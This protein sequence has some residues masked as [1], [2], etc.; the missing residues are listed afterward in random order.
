M[1]KITWF[2]ITVI[3]IGG[4]LAS[5]SPVIGESGIS[6]GSVDLNGD[7]V[8]DATIIEVDGDG[9]PD[10]VDSDGDG[11]IDLPWSD[12]FKIIPT[13]DGGASDPGHNRPRHN[14]A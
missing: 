2:L 4:L 10:G 11:T 3:I 7:G 14:R 12:D 13:D 5:C 6:I 1:K 8:S 9:A